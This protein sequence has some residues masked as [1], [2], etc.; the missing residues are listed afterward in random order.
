VTAAAV[1]SPVAQRPS[2]LATLPSIPTVERDDDITR[3]SRLLRR[4]DPDSGLLGGDIAPYGGDP[5]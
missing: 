4:V 2:V 5:G 1:G 3:I